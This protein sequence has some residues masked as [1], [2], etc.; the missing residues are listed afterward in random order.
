MNESLAPP[1]ETPPAETQQITATNPE[2]GQKIV[3]KNGQ[4]FDFKTNRPVQ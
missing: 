3:F 4:W 2:T 1:A